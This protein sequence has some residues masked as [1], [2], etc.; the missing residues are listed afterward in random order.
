VLLAPARAARPHDVGRPPAGAGCPF[1]PGNEAATP[2]ETQALRPGG[3]PPDSPGWLVRAVPNKFPAVAP[4]EG[5][6]EVI[7]N[8]PRHVVRLGDLTD[9]EAVLAG[10]VWADRIAAVEA[11]P[12]GLWPFLFLNQGAAAGASLQHIH[13]QI[14]GLPLEPPR[15]LAR[16]RAFE[17]TDRCPVCADL[18]AAREDGRAVDEDGG[19]VAWTPAVPPLTGTLRIGPAA[20][21]P[22]WTADPGPGAAA[23]FLRRQAARA[24]EGLGAE[25]LNL[26]LHRRRRGGGDRYH[27]H[28][29]LIPRLGT[30]AGLELGTGVI[31]VASSSDEIAS[32][33]RGA[34][35]GVR[36]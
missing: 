12:R 2:P 4:G 33:L 14:V 20:H 11:D 10:G 29:D 32:R 5:V 24:S 8:T 22:D 26:W 15:L 36:T 3:G 21:L 16:E 17:E 31:A 19:L 23:A 1:C 27:W 25:A 34:P 6:H 35:A 30:L 18:A 13:T 7:V 9:D 28:V